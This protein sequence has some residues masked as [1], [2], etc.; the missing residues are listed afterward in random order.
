LSMKA[1]RQLRLGIHVYFQQ[2]CLARHLVSQCLKIRGGCAARSAPIRP[3]IHQD[4]DR[5]F[6]I[7]RNGSVRLARSTAARARRVPCGNAIGR[8]ASWTN[9][10]EGCAHRMTMLRQQRRGRGLDG[11][12]P[13]EA[14]PGLNPSLRA[15][16]RGGSRA[17][18]SNRRRE[19]KSLRE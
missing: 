7:N 11:G 12:A 8:S 3:E 6:R 10:S 4:G 18:T 16:S 17:G 14:V 5:R 2:V 13:R 19:R 15:R 1:R 9:A